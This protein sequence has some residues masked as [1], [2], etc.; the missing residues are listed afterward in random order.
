MTIRNQLKSTLVIGLTLCLMTLGS[1][2][3]NGSFV[4]AD[5][6]PPEVEAIKAEALEGKFEFE[7]IGTSKLSDAIKEMLQKNHS[8]ILN[9]EAIGA[10]NIT[11]KDA[12]TGKAIKD[13]QVYLSFSA[14]RSTVDTSGNSVQTANPFLLFDLGKSGADGT[15]TFNET[16]YYNTD[17]IEAGTPPFATNLQVHLAYVNEEDPLVVIDQSKT[18]YWNA[19]GSGTFEQFV[20]GLNGKTSLPLSQLKTL[21][22]DVAKETYNEKLRSIFNDGFARYDDGVMVRVGSAEQFSKLTPEKQLAISIGDLRQYILTERQLFIDYVAKR[23]YKDFGG[24]EPDFVIQFEP[25]YEYT[26]KYKDGSTATK[27]EQARLGLTIFDEATGGTGYA[28]NYSFMSY[29]AYVFADGYQTGKSIGTGIRQDFVDV[30]ANSTI[31]LSKNTAPVVSMNTYN[32]LFGTLKD[33]SGAPIVGAKIKITNTD[34]VAT[35]NAKGEFSFVTLKDEA[36]L[37]EIVSGDNGAPLEGYAIFDGKGYAL[38]AL[39]L[40]FS[41]DQRVYRIELVTGE[42]P[43]GALPTADG[44]SGL[45]LQTMAIIAVVGVVVVGIIMV[46]F[47]MI[48]RRKKDDHQ[49]DN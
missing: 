26:E 13:A 30:N 9:K 6:L 36:L 44:K 25:P 5:N 41:S 48:K 18:P 38:N 22:K 33:P 34:R 8:I 16:Y 49:R 15:F 19:E 1:L 37:L 4:F 2:G 11:V 12:D 45:S 23:S 10:L 7:Y 27:E 42:M 20:K 14:R 24:F 39:P 32:T 17:V 47:L 35:S 43:K 29:R 31:Y 21:L 46:F 28:I 40:S 3:G